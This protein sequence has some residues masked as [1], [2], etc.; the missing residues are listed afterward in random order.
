MPLSLLFLPPGLP[1]KGSRL[2]RGTDSLF[3]QDSRS[4]EPNQ[5]DSFHTT[6]QQEPRAYLTGRSILKDS[7]HFFA[8]KAAK[9]AKS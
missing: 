4:L 2:F 7:Q 1:A 5:L 3:T 6:G 9:P 8:G